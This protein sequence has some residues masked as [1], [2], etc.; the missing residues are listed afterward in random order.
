MGV[1]LFFHL[2]RQKQDKREDMNDQFQMS[3]YGL[4][5]VPGMKRKSGPRRTPSKLSLE[6]SP[7]DPARMSHDPL[8]SARDLPPGHLNPFMSSDDDT[9]IRAAVEKIIPP[10]Q[11]AKQW[12]AKHGSTGSSPKSSPSPTR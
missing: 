10:D 2:K 9:S 11:A 1:L 7:Y 4:D 6:G 12:P 3:D 8:R 5:E